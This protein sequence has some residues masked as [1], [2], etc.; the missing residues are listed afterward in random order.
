VC[1]FKKKRHRCSRFRA[2]GLSKHALARADESLLDIKA[3]Q[4]FRG[5]RAFANAAVAAGSARAAF[6]V[7]SVDFYCEGSDA[8]ARDTERVAAEA[9]SLVPASL[10]ARANT[11]ADGG[12]FSKKDDAPS[13]D[14]ASFPALQSSLQSSRDA[15]RARGASLLARAATA[16]VREAHHTL[17]VMHFNGSGGRRR[18]KDPE[19]GAALCARGNLLFDCV[20]AKRELGHCLQDGFGVERDAALGAKLLDEAAAA[21]AKSG[22]GLDAAVLAASAAAAIV[23]ERLRKRNDINTLNAAVAAAAEV[24]AAAKNAAAAHLTATRENRFLLDWYGDGAASDP[25]K[26]P[27]GPFATLPTGTTSCSHPLCGRVETRRHE[28]RRCSCCGRVRYCSR[29]CQGADWR[30]Q[31]KFACLPLL[32]LYG[33]SESDAE[34]VEGEEQGEADLQETPVLA[35]PCV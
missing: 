26:K 13:A 11:G 25:A 2:A 32:E 23:E 18:D 31:H 33:W 24:A 16:G 10:N 22:K 1:P 12:V 17:A 8:N 19:A 9:G 14:G 15:R 35:Q 4:W 20:S 29:S 28:F 3:A 34:S 5:A 6:F 30:L 21:D 27:E 7:G